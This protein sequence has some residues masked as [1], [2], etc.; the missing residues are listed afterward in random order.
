ME[1]LKAKDSKIKRGLKSAFDW[2][3]LFG[4]TSERKV[5]PQVSNAPEFQRY[6]VPLMIV[7]TTPTL[8][9]AISQLFNVA[10]FD[11][12]GLQML[13]SQEYSSDRN[14]P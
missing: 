12:H 11:P 4:G 7:K 10:G 9:E 8:Q 13:D 2:E 1:R 14:Q 6:K 3:K 5:S